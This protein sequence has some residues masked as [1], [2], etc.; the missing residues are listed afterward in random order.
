MRAD[1][2]QQTDTPAMD[3]LADGGVV[4]F[5]SRVSVPSQTRVNFVTIPTGA[6][7]DRHGIVGGS[8]YDEDFNLVRTDYPDPLTAQDNVLVPTIFEVLEEKGIRTAY[9]ATKGYELVGGRGAS[10][11][12]GGRDDFP[13]YIW[14]HRYDDEV[15]GSSERSLELKLEMD[16]IVLAKMKEAVR[17]EGA[18]FFIANLGALDYIG[19]KH[20][21]ETPY[22]SR[23]LG[24]ADARIQRFI[25]FL[26]RE[27]IYSESAI[28]I[29]SDHGFTH[30]ENP[31]NVLMG[32][33]RQPAV[34]ELAGAGIKHE[35]LSRG[36]L[37]FSLYLKDPGKAER[38]LEIL[39]TIEWVSKIYSEHPLEDLDGTLSDLNY[40]FPGRTGDFFIDVAPTHTL[41]FDNKGQHG[42]TAD[43][44]MIVPLIFSGRNIASGVRLEYSESVDI[45]PTVL[46]VY[47]LDNTKYL[48]AAGNILDGVIEF[49]N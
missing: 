15:N 46:A 17:D 32:S 10:I 48:E 1:K 2:M 37:S 20:G 8:Y 18:E 7:A 33:R 43:T 34:R 22:Y 38:A 35:A 40:Y 12:F 16:E 29:T 28:I 30:I 6:H 41:N 3:Y 11:T 49:P 23:A 47:G 5:N 24:E 36:G 39:R 26:K 19:H 42:S 9:I 31:E 14:R 21:V 45:A 44:D 25:D 27:E 13:P 4:S